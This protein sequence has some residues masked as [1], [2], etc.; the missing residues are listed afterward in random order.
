MQQTKFVRLLFILFLFEV[1][2]LQATE[3]D[4]IRPVDFGFVPGA[5]SSPET[6]LQYGVV[7]QL[8]FD[9]F[10]N[11]TDSR[12]SQ[13]RLALA[14]STKSQFQVVNAFNIFGRNESYYIDGRIEYQ[15]WVDRHYGIG[16][17]A[18]ISVV[19]RRENEVQFDSLNFH[20]F[21]INN[22]RFKFSYNKKLYSGLFLGLI[23]EYYDGWNFRP[24]AEEAIYNT[25]EIN[26]QQ[27]NGSFLGVGLNLFWDTRDN[28]NSPYTGQYTQLSWMRYTDWFGMDFQFTKLNFEFRK[29][30]QIEDR[31]ILAF[32]VRSHNVF[33]SD[34]VP[35]EAYNK[36]GGA[37]FV[38]GYFQGTYQDRHALGMT[39]EYRFPIFP[40]S[41]APKL[42][43]WKHIQAAV[44][45]STAQTFGEENSFA[46]SQTHVSLGGGIRMMIRKLQRLKVRIDF[47][48]GLTEGSAGPGLN[49][50]GIYVDLNEAF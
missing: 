44:F 23:T 34:L 28:I 11:N 18:N 47:G 33:N 42:K 37:Q 40:V 22:F 25:P 31:H 36:L 17:D 4:T 20:N 9:A 21:A 49:Q 15:K 43:F 45:I 5:S 3:Q 24:V 35:F 10:K 27:M 48:I 2:A 16:N 46:I 29:Y 1:Q 13:V 41:D 32:R 12:M 26:P 19:E 50:S 30:F 39:A 38:R 8:A 6:G 14:A 7:G